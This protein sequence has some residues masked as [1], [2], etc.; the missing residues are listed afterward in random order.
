M[1]PKPTLK[2]I[3]K[4]PFRY[5]Y[6]HIYDTKTKA[7][8]HVNPELDFNLGHEYRELLAD[9]LNDGW[10]KKFGEPLQWIKSDDPRW[11]RECP[12]CNGKFHFMSVCCN[13]KFHF[14]SVLYKHC[15]ECGVRLLEPE[16]AKNAP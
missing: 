3:L 16:E 10:E 4:P 6:G 2:E 14:R 11:V 8:C 12:N 9:A 15:P 13:E 7:V 5:E 1:K